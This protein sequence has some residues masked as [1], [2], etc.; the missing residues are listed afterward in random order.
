MRRG[1]AM[2]QKWTFVSNFL[3]PQLPP[4][5]YVAQGAPPCRLLW[6]LNLK[7]S[8]YQAAISAGRMR[9]PTTL[10]VSLSTSTCGLS[11][12]QL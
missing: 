2:T 1:Y 11:G 6:L 10:K 12:R 9:S 8:L 7:K 3:S 4:F 5:V